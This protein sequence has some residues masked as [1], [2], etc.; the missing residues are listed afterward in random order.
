MVIENSGNYS[1]SL[2]AN[3]Q[4]T[5][6]EKSSGT[7][8]TPDDGSGKPLAAAIHGQVIAAEFFRGE[9]AIVFKE[10]TPNEPRYLVWLMDPAW[11]P[12]AASRPDSQ[13]I[14]T[15]AELEASFGVTGGASG[16]GGGAVSIIENFGQWRLEQRSDSTYQAVNKATNQAFQIKDY[17]GFLYTSTMRAADDFNG[18]LGV[19]IEGGHVW[20]VDSSW[21][22]APVGPNGKDT[23]NLSPGDQALYFLTDAPPSV[24]GPTDQP[25]PP[26]PPPPPPSPPTYALSS[27]AASVNEGDVASFTLRTTNVPGG[28]RESFLISGVD[29]DDLVS[30]SLRGEVITEAS[31]VTKITLPIRADNKTEGP[32]TLRLSIQ[33]QTASVVINDTSVSLP[34]TYRITAT[35]ATVD[36]GSV[37]TFN[38]VTTNV[39]AGSSVQWTITGVEASDIVGGQLTGRATVGANGQATITIPIAADNATEGD[40]VLTL[41]VETASASVVIK[42]TSVGAP[43]TYLLTGPTQPV[44]AGSIVTF[45][46]QT[47]NVKAGTELDYQISGVTAQAIVGQKLTGSVTVGADGKASVQIPLAASIPGSG[48][49]ALVLTVKGASAS[50]LVQPS[51]TASSG[52][53]I[54]GTEAAELINGTTLNDRIEALRGNDTIVSSTGSDTIDGGAGMDLVRYNSSSLSASFGKQPTGEITVRIGSDTDTL[55]NVERLQF[56]DQW[57]AIDLNGNGGVASRMIVSAFGSQA[58]KDFSGIGISLVDS[59]WTTS[60]LAGLIISAGFLPSGNNEFVKAVFEN[61]TGRA[62]NALEITIFAQLLNDGSYDQAGLLALAADSPLAQAI[63]EQ[64][65]IGLVGIPYQPSL[66]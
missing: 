24:Y 56:T 2:E 13:P 17:G 57:I 25:P 7:R 29:P 62:P 12:Y 39:S 11:K 41:R 49:I 44:T 47:S 51:A 21:T 45:L 23:E 55:I 61:V 63:V 10:G 53:K 26:P 19:M 3:G 32:E 38:L 42:D 28:S 16:S 15:Q 31:G 48:N 36:E 35:S 30:N 34:P 1:L 59:G 52:N 43:P 14:I 46:L 9:R 8:W 6:T 58:L 40:E 54:S 22:K 4:Y 66:I 18:R 37:A 50:A 27:D 60:Q 65:A 64:S 5:V 33:G 20:Y